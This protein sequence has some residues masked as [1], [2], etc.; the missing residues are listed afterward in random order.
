MSDELR[1]RPATLRDVPFLVES[2][3]ALASETEDK[4]L[5]RA[6][7]EKGVASVFADA[8]RGFY[9][10]AER[11]ETSVGCLLVTFEWSDWRNGDWWWIQSVYV[12]ASARRRGVFRAAYA[13]VE[14]RA[15]A[16]EG[17]VGLR[18][19]V[20]QENSAAQQTYASLG[21]EDSG[22]RLLQSGFSDFGA[23]PKPSG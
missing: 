20:E 6:V 3:A 9:L 12:V 10:I 7:L 23:P 21:M 13:E 4:T 16:T 15:R 11:A 14:R 18:L 2:N 22:Y 5:D 19:Y 8:R 1:I 17:V